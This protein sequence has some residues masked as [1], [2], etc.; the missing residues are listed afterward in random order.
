[1]NSIGSQCDNTNL[2]E[3]DIMS[4]LNSYVDSHPNIVSLWKEYIKVKRINYMKAIVDCDYVVRNLETN[5]DIS[6]ETIAML[7]A[8]FD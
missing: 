1:M 6:V 2:L 4:R 3:D 5:R 7:Y 8:L